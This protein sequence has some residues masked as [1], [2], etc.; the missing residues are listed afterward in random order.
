V[1]HL[2]VVRSARRDALQAFLKERGIETGI[3]YPIALPK[4]KAYEYCGQANE[5]MRANRFDGEVLS[6]PIGDHMDAA[7]AGE[8]AEA[9][10]A[11][12]GTR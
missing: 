7:D 5:D 2:F 4:L 10:R 1:Y 11:F 9:C 12:F 6:L 8:V 3:H